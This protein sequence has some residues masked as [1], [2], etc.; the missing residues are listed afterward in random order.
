MQEIQI[1]SSLLHG[2][3]IHFHSNPICRWVN[4][5]TL[6]TRSDSIA[7]CKDLSVLL[8]FLIVPSFSIYCLKTHSTIFKY[9]WAKS[10][11]F[12][13][14]LVTNPPKWSSVNPPIWNSVSQHLLTSFPASCLPVATMWHLGSKLSSINSEKIDN[15]LD[16]YSSNPSNINKMIFLFDFFIDFLQ[17]Q[18]LIIN[19]FPNIRMHFLT[20]QQ[21]YFFECCGT[22]QQNIWTLGYNVLL[23]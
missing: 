15:I 9:S 1:Q 3:P 5:S 6:L 16:G 23:I 14:Y 22:T 17:G 12:L 11:L 21:Q 4:H 13:K 18:K 2:F 20:F 8:P 19:G 10:C 7:V